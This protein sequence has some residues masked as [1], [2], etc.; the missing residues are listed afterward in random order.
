MRSVWHSSD[1]LDDQE[2]VL[3]AT[4]DTDI[5]EVPASTPKFIPHTVRL[6]RVSSFTI[7][8][9]VDVTTGASKLIC[10]ITVPATLL[11]VTVL[12]DMPIASSF[13]KTHVTL[14]FD[15]QEEVAQMPKA[16]TVIDCVKS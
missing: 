15:V 7:A 11:T 10:A 6:K 13:A 2:A 3:Q 8:G 9:A 4:A 16:P 1:V 14:L 5:V 12:P